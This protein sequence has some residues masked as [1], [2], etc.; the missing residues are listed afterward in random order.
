ML[1]VVN[2][3]SRHSVGSVGTGQARRESAYNFKPL[4]NTTNRTLAVSGCSAVMKLTQI[5]TRIW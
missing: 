4:H 2:D 5:L 3:R 1:A